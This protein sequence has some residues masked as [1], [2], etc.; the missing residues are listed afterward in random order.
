MTD[1]AR[2]FI[3]IL[4][5]PNSGKSTLTG[6]LCSCIDAHV[7]RPR[8][9]IRQ[10]IAEQPYAA[11]LLTPVDDM[12]WVSDYALAYAVRTT[13]S[14]LSPAV[15]RVILENLPW[16]A[17]QLLDLQYLAAQTSSY[18]AVL[19][20]DAPDDLLMQRGSRRRVCHTCEPDP[21]REPR[22]PAPSALDDNDR[23]G[24]CGSR[25]TVRPDDTPAI[26]TRRIERSRRYLLQIFHYADAV[27]I[28]IHWLDGTQPVAEVARSAFTILS[29]LRDFESP[30]RAILRDALGPNV[31]GG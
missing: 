27:R 30:Q 18:L 3:S 14:T 11:D 20:V 13:I 23:C 12:G 10:T 2:L 7:I 22:R 29:H 6:A 31:E 28:P 9:A 5:P 1:I 16:D 24:E 26:L 21:T 4:G 25:L 19:F 8:D 15:Q 17:L